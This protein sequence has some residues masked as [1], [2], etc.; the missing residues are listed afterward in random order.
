MGKAISFTIY[1]SAQSAEFLTVSDAMKQ[2]LDMVGALETTEAGDAAERQIVWRLT[3][4]HTNSPPFT[5]TAEAYSRDPSV[6]VVIEA[7][8]V[9]KLFATTVREV[10]AGERPGWIE[11][12]TARLLQQALKRNLNGVGET[13][14]II[15]DE[16]VSVVPTTARIGLEA[17]ARVEAP[18]SDKSRVEYGSVEGQVIGLTTYYNN[19][20]LVLVER[21]SGAHIVCSLTQELAERLGP[22]HN[23]KDAWEGSRLLIGGEIVYGQAGDIKRVN[24]SYYTELKWTDVPRLR[25][26][27]IDLLQGRT[28]HEHLDQFWG[29]RF[30]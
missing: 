25:L 13:K 14:I 23:W 10:L 16:T 20:A 21:L 8:R 30:G 22:N 2:I 6:S 27:G 7:T 19:P 26:K 11:E 12:P 29:E 1:P 3:E 4:A 28:V 18:L 24:A 17:L 15:D 5:V 9:T